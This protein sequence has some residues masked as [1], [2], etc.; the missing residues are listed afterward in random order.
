MRGWWVG[1]LLL[2][3]SGVMAGGG[4]GAPVFDVWRTHVSRAL[5]IALAVPDGKDGPAL[6]D[7]QAFPWAE[8]G[9]QFE[10]AI[11]LAGGRTRVEVFTDPAERPLEL[12]F[13][14][15]LGF[16]VDERTFVSTTELAPGV[17]AVVV[18]QPRSPHTFAR[19]TTVL[20]LGAWT[21]VATCEGLDH[22]AEG[23]ENTKLCDVVVRS[24]RPALPEELLP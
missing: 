13:E 10:H 2:L 6:V 3:P 23:P 20:R 19:R 17:P 22:P 16:L 8:R 4:A 18:E 14:Q 11:T 12:W 9:V 21:L 24:L 15:H 1:L 7:E 5:G